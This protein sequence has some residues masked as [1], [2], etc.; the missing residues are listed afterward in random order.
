MQRIWSIKVTNNGP[1]DATGVEVNDS[2]ITQHEFVSA[3]SKDY[4]SST[5]VWKVGD[6]A[7]GESKEL[8]VTVRI[9]DAGEFSNAVTVSGDQHDNDTS[10]NNASSDNVTVSE[11]PV[12]PEESDDSDDSDGP[13][14]SDDSEESDGPEESDEGDEQNEPEKGISVAA[15]PKAGNPLLVLLLSLMILTGAMF[16][17]KE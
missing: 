17:R 9:N 4:N 11:P 10:N 12:D 1:N 5:G 8:T 6:L 3:S 2:D 7:N 13:E 16:E 15:L 14:E